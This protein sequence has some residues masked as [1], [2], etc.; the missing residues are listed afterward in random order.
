MI[1]QNSNGNLE[2]SLALVNA[3]VENE[4]VTDKV[5]QIISIDDNEVELDLPDTEQL[6]SVL[7]MYPEFTMEE[8]VVVNEVTGESEVV[9][10]GSPMEITVESDVAP[11]SVEIN[12]TDDSVIEETPQV[13]DITTPEVEN[14][15]NEVTIDDAD[16]LEDIQYFD[17]PIDPTSVDDETAKLED[18]ISLNQF[19]M[20]KIEKKSVS[21]QQFNEETAGI[22]PEALQPQVEETEKKDLA[23]QEEIPGD[24]L[25]SVSG[26]IEAFAKK[27][28]RKSFAEEYGADKLD[29]VV[30]DIKSL[31]EHYSDVDEKIKSFVTGEVPAGEIEAQVEEAAEVV[32]EG[33]EETATTVSEQFA[34]EPEVE[35]KPEEVVE[36]PEEQPEEEVQVE[37][38]SEEEIAEAE[39]KENEEET[40]EEVVEEPEEES[41]VEDPESEQFCR[42]VGKLFSAAYREDGVKSTKS[43]MIAAAGKR[44]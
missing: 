23:E 5:T 6:R 20:S 1:L 32:T 15:L 30:D 14:Q 28:N 25:S 26:R 22:A 33:P 31:M 36:Q 24:G 38:F 42:R 37:M 18:E 21:R 12:G 39:S 9:N 35:E 27:L 16:V 13:D 17:L 41:E 40:A 29:Q 4:I 8:Q 2:S 3:L 11:Q 43:A 34:E 10:E 7:A 44:Q 19:T